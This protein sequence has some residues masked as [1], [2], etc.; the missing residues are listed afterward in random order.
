[1]VLAGSGSEYNLPDIRGID[2]GSRHNAYA[3]G[4]L[5]DKARY[6]GAAFQ[7]RRSVTGGEK[8]V[9]AKGDDV[10]KGRAWLGTLVESPVEGNFERTGSP[11]EA[12]YKGDVDLAVRSEGPYNYSID[13]QPFTNGDVLQN[14]F[15]LRRR[16]AKVPF[17]WTHKDIYGDAYSLKDFGY[18]PLRRAYSAHFEPGA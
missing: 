17:P 1:M 11:N 10:F 7:G 15:R 3:P 14:L 12:G 8:G 18:E 5:L 4:G 9:T 13:F 16:V 6:K 2:S